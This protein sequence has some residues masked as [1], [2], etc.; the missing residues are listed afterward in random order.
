MKEARRPSG[1]FWNTRIKRWEL[2]GD[3]RSLLAYI[4]SSGFNTSLTALTLEAVTVGSLLTTQEINTTLTGTIR[5]LNVPSLATLRAITTAGLSTLTSALITTGTIT[6]A[7]VG[8]TATIQALTTAGLS[9]LTS[10]LITTGTATN[11]NVGTLATIRSFSTTG[12]GSI[13]DAQIAGLTVGASGTKL[14]NLLKFT[15]TIAGIAAIGS[16]AVAVGTVTGMTVTTGDSIFVTP[17]VTL[18]GHVGIVG[19][20]CPSTN[21]VNVFIANHKPDS[22]GSLPDTGVDVWVFR[23]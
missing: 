17:K 7:N 10:A 4:S 14:L 23:S 15:G 8:S 20:L 19:A 6:N 5:N 22:A 11:V 12:V 18:T 21:T 2:Y 13:G 9:T 3:G 1:W 16:G